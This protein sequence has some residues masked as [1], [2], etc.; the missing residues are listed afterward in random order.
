M[1]L[2]PATAKYIGDV[3]KM[4]QKTP[5]DWS[6]LSIE[7][8]RQMC[9][10]YQSQMGPIADKITI[11]ECSLPIT[12]RVIIKAKIFNVAG[13][14]GTTKPGLIYIPG[15]GFIAYLNCHDSAL[16]I[17][18]KYSSYRVI[19]IE[20]RLAP[21]YQAPIPLEDTCNA[22]RYIFANADIFSLDINHIALGGDSSGA[23]LSL[24]AALNFRDVSLEGK[25]AGDF[26]NI[27]HLI[28]VSGSYDLS[29]SIRT[30]EYEKFEKEDFLSDDNFNY[31]FNHYLG[32]I[33][34]DD[35]LVSPYFR[36]TTGLPDT[37][38]IVAEYDGVR[39]QTE[40]MA[41][42]LIREN[43]RVNK[44]VVPGQT[45]SFLLLRGVMGEGIDPA[46]IVVDNLNAIY[47]VHKNEF[48]CG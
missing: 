1:P 26:P 14:E 38:L 46:T 6:I 12:D 45:H 41:E 17:I 40:A 32:S 4:I 39:S 35:P 48:R 37:T 28:L 30:G 31:M 8:Y 33:K 43:V 19:M 47:S 20:P 36:I 22:I 24:A 44:I 16:S 3:K 29:M 15:G 42:K 10:G 5:L 13:E 21:E 11:Q 27:E 25:Q 23:N 34:R 7:A 9:D 2:L 18:A